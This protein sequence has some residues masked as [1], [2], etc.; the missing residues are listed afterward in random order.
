M[1][2]ESLLVLG[3]AGT[4]KTTYVQG[5]VER[6]RH[7]G[8]RVDIISKT[9]TASRR[10]GGV[11]ADHWVRRHVLHG[12]AT[13][14]YLWV[15]EISQV[16]IGLLNQLGKLSFTPVHVL[17]SGD[18]HQSPPIN[19]CWK[20]TPVPEDA[21]EQSSLLHTLA[22]GN[23]CTLTEC[24]RGDRRLVNTIP[25]G[26]GC[27]PGKRN[28]MQS[29]GGGGMADRRGL[30]PRLLFKT[31]PGGKGAGPGKRNWM[32][33]SGWMDDRRGL[34]PRLLFKTTPG[35]KGAGTIGFK[36]RTWDPPGVS[37]RVKVQEPRGTFGPVCLSKQFLAGRDPAQGK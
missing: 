33:C 8:K 27:N 30:R 35:G 28:W 29:S 21:L 31:T 32:L 3:I 36:V 13:C 20:G 25:V 18:F 7:S 11:T 12:A 4:G 16:D 26:K 37:V 14:D 22:G 19:N 17:L 34:R 15:D 9:H 2:G 10:A 23:R 24:R 1:R 5:I 6:L